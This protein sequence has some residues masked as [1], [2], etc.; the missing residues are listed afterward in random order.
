MSV[1]SV[2]MA[3]HFSLP[4]DTEEDLVGADWHQSA[5]V[6]LYDSLVDLAYQQ[7]HPWHVG[8]QLTLVAWTPS[9][10][11]WR[12]MPDIMVHPNAGPQPRKE[13]VVEQ[14]GAPALVIEVASETTWR[15]DVNTKDGKAAGYLSLGVQE[16]LVFDPLGDYLPERCR[17]WRRVGDTIE[18]WRPTPEG[19]YESRTLGIS[20]QPEDTLLRVIDGQ[21]RPV[22]SGIEKT[23]E[24]ARLR[25]QLAAQQGSP[26]HPGNDR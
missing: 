7:G 9:G 23:Q 15:Y 12:P 4:D 6:R 22:L 8:N 5:I 14:D 17:G 3:A 20:F 18:V 21:G 16:Y 1:Q 24:I 26:S 10:A 19:R 25:A 11:A 13:M 2:D